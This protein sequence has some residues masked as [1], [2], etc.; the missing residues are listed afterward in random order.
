MVNNEF[1]HKVQ[2]DTERIEA[3][4]PCSS[5]PFG[6]PPFRPTWLVPLEYEYRCWRDRFMNHTV[7]P[8]EPLV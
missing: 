1:T 8:P 7:A 2:L 4:Q 3:F 6:V 5:H